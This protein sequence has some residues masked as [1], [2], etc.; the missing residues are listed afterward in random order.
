M[1]LLKLHPNPQFC[2]D[3][4]DTLSGE[5]DDSLHLGKTGT[6]SFPVISC[7]PEQA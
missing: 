1:T 3:D 2:N 5:I 6:L 4:R 7:T